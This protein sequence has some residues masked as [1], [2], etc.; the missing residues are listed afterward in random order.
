MVL[1]YNTFNSKYNLAQSVKSD[2]SEWLDIMFKIYNTKL[3]GGLRI[4]F[5]TTGYK[6]G[7]YYIKEPFLVEGDYT[8]KKLPNNLFK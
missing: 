1:E 3:I 4:L 8:N 7:S 2:G 6:G 5:G